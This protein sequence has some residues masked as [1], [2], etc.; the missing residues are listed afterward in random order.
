MPTFQIPYLINQTTLNEIEKNSFNFNY[1]N[2]VDVQKQFMSK[3]KY[4]YI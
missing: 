4:T 3:I 1:K 2:S